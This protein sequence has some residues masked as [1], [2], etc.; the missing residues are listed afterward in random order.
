MNPA[1][2]KRR[3]ERCVVD[4]GCIYRH[5]PLVYLTK[6]LA[7]LLGVLTVLGII[8]CLA[9]L[10][11]EPAQRANG[12]SREAN[13]WVGADARCESVCRSCLQMQMEA[14]RADIV[15]C[16]LNLFD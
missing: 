3:T 8:V 13:H 9:G 15:P 4:E 1:I 12:W 5:E 6:Q 11:A 2:H 16:V 10:A 14:R 7:I